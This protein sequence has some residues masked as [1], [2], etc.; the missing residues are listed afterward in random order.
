MSKWEAL[1]GRGLGGTA[2]MV[3]LWLQGQGREFLALVRSTKVGPPLYSTV[4]LSRSLGHLEPLPSPLA[5]LCSSQHPEQHSLLC[6]SLQYKLTRNHFWVPLHHHGSV[7]VQS[8]ST[9]GFPSPGP[10]A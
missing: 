4:A 3:S 6:V 8:W 1:L 5:P 9:M 10:T 7:P 2:L